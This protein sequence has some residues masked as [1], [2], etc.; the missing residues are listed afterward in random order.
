MGQPQFLGLTLALIFMSCIAG[1]FGLLITNGQSYFATKNGEDIGSNAL[2][3]YDKTLEL[4]NATNQIKT[5][6]SEMKEKTGV[7]DVLGAWFSNAYRILITIPSLLVNMVINVIT[8]SIQIFG[9]GEAG[10]ILQT[11]LIIA[12]IA[13]IFIGILLAVLLKVGQL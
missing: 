9:L 11:G 12:F 3:N 8:N 7:V 1:V 5:D 4:Q 13:T 2:I 6:L 10:Q